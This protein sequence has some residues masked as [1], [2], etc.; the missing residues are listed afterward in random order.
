MEYKFVDDEYVSA[1]IN[2][3]HKLQQLSIANTYAERIR[4]QQL[5]QAAIKQIKYWIED[6]GVV[7]IDDIDMHH[8]MIAYD[9]AMKLYRKSK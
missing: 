3:V 7:K 9:T 5:W 2:I 8:Q 4:K 1:M 6:A